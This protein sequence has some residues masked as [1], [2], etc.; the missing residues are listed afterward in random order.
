MQKADRLEE[1][2]VTAG[3]DG[4]WSALLDQRERAQR[5]ALARCGT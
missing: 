2:H 5:V 1:L 4:V 3:R